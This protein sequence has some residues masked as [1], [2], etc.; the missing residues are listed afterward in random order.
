MLC[1]FY[2]TEYAF[3]ARLS[4]S[5]FVVFIQVFFDKKSLDYITNDNVGKFSEKKNKRLIKC[6]ADRLVVAISSVPKTTG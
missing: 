6:E 2:M 1:S 5:I 4:F 3:C